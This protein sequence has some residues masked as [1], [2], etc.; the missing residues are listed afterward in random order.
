M[1][2]GERGA[3]DPQIMWTDLVSEQRERLLAVVGDDLWGIELLRFAIQQAVAELAGL[4]G[5][6]HLGTPGYGGG[7]RLAVASGLPRAFTQQWERIDGTG[8]LA[9]AR[10]FRDGAFARASMAALADET[11]EDGATASGRPG[12]AETGSWSWPVGT[13]MAA[14]PI[15]GPG[16][17]IGTR[18]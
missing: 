11:P 1:G 6:V 15:L 14:V 8:P 3:Q 2:M 4:G 17:P 12:R 10:A 18:S 16:G 13:A 7:L 9:P 5:M